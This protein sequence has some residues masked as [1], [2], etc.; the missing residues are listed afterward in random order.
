MN[1]PQPQ[2]DPNSHEGMADELVRLLTQS[3]IQI[4]V[5]AVDRF[6]EVKAWLMSIRDGNLTVVETPQDG[7]NS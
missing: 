7:L 4:P 6:V 5:Q 1:N 2:I 3:N